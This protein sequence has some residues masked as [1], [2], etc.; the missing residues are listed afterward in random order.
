MSKRPPLNSLCRKYLIYQDLVVLLNHSALQCDLFT[1]D[2]YF[3]L[4]YF[5]RDSPPQDLKQREL[6]FLSPASRE[7]E[8]KGRDTDTRRK[9]EIKT[10]EREGEW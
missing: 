4:W 10:K 3:L 2:E 6:T 8:K 7:T 9:G 5:S 1:V